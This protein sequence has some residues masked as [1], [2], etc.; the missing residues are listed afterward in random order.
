MKTK[1]KVMIIA[2]VVAVLALGV[3]SFQSSTSAEPGII[4]PAN[5]EADVVTTLPAVVATTITTTQPNDTVVT[6]TTQ[7]VATSLPPTTQ[8]PAVAPGS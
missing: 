3:F 7:P 5:S 4:Q 8:P 2:A 1:T 6:T